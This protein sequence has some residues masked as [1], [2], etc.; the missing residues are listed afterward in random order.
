MMLGHKCAESIRALFQLQL[1]VQEQRKELEVRITYCFPVDELV[2]GLHV[3]T[4]AERII[5]H[6]PVFPGG[7]DA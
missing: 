1:V 2:N 7:H 5:R 4:V 3:H 6:R